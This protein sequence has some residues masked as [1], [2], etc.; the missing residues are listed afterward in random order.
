MAVWKSKEQMIARFLSGL[1]PSI[2]DALSLHQLWSVSKTYN[3]ALMFEKQ[4][5]RK[6][7]LQ[8]HAYGGSKSTQ[9]STQGRPTNNNAQPFKIDSAGLPLT[10]GTVKPVPKVAQRF[11]FKCYKCGEARHKA[12]DCKKGGVNRGQ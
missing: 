10:S 5:A 7:F 4:L 11:T 8:F 3:R 1:K 12:T 6:A 2:Q 9:V